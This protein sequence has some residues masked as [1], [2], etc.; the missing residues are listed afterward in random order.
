MRG[1]AIAVASG[2]TNERFI[3]RE[4]REWRQKL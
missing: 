4:V 1:M 3:D 2:A